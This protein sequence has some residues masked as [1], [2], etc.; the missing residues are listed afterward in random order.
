[1]ALRG[2]R[3][4]GLDSLHYNIARL[5]CLGGLACRHMHCV[6][7]EGGHSRA[8][9]AAATLPA[10]ERT[11]IPSGDLSRPTRPRFLTLPCSASD[12]EAA[13][14]VWIALLSPPD[15]LRHCSSRYGAQEVLP[16][17]R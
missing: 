9:L 2:S 16:T 17:L 6:H 4:Q 7:E 14:C 10:L 13:D 11:W 1:M 3:L 8:I 12:V 15:R 5:T